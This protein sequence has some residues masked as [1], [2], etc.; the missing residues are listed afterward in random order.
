MRKKIYLSMLALAGTF[1]A[2]IPAANAKT[3]RA[4]FIGNSY[5]ATNNIPNILKSIAIS[6]GDELVYDAVT[7]GGTTF[8]AHCANPATISRIAEGNWDYVVLQEQSQMPAFPDEQ[9]ATEVYPYARQ[10]DSLVKL[11][12]PCGKTMFYMTWGR[13]NGDAANCPFFPPIC[14]YDG[15]DSML[16]HRYTTMAEDNNALLAPVGAA[17]HYLRDEHPDIEL[18]VADESHPSYAG[19]YLAACTFYAMMFQKSPMMASYGGSLSSPVATIIRQAVATVVYDSMVHWTRFYPAVQAGFDLVIDDLSVSFTNMA[20]HAD[21]VKW[22]FGDG[23]T[24]NDSDPLHHYA[25]EGTYEIM[26]VAYHCNDTDTARGNVVI[27]S[28]G[29]SDVNGL[30]GWTMYPNPANEY[31]IVDIAAPPLSMQ[32]VDALGRKVEVSIEQ[33]GT[34]YSL[35]VATIP[36]GIYHVVLRTAQGWVAKKF[37]KQ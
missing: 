27:G 5:V 1:I 23:N 17:W 4:L 24:S 11:Y 26:Q 8:M 15:M 2:S 7:P 35:S 12:N 10:L 28:T 21:S 13:K 19:S 25:A 18:Y 9:V 20:T 37:I 34:K 31:V 14:T 16:H 36:S 22:F 32:V 30:F 3:V 6:T 33:D 29:I